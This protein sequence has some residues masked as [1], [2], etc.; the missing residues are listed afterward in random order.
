MEVLYQLVAVLCL[1][2][3]VTGVESCEKLQYKHFFNS[4]EECEAE[5]PN[6]HATLPLAK[7]INGYEDY[8]TKV[9][10]CRSVGEA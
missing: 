3:P 8:T 10:E 2:N 7:K 1:T 4:R 9:V 6:S 5:I